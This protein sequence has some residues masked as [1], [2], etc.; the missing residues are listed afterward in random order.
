MQQKNNFFSVLKFTY[1]QGIKAKWFHITTTVVILFILVGLN[2]NSIGNLFN[3]SSDD[4]HKIAVMNNTG[5]VSSKDLLKNIKSS[6]GQSEY[7][8]VFETENTAKNIKTKTSE[9]DALI[10]INKIGEKSTVYYESKVSDEVL[11]NDVI[12]MADSISRTLYATSCGLNSNQ[13]NTLLS[14][15]MVEKIN[16]SN[17]NYNLWILSFVFIILLYLMISVYGISIAN[18]IV[19]EKSNRIVETLLCYAKPF[20]LMF[21]KIFGF[22]CIA[23]TQISIWGLTTTAFIRILPIPDFAIQ[24]LNL[25]VLVLLVINILLG[26]LIYS[27]VFA[28]LA[29]FADNSQDSNQLMMPVTIILIVSLYSSMFI[30]IDPTQPLAYFFSYVPFLAPIAFTSIALAQENI[31][32]LQ[33]V[34]NC[35]VQIA[36]IIIVGIICSR[37][38]CKGVLGGKLFKGIKKLKFKQQSL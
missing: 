15:D 19:E 11:S 9:Y 24:H 13:I 2:I 21:G 30:S 17:T 33:I 10:V 23:L 14:K 5:T 1:L 3:S 31:S 18:S 28:A 34:I 20:D 25:K 38:Y 7:Y 4:I 35:C 27:C 6:S 36:E 8:E 32:T 12:G 29:S 16:Y 26:F 22:L 37:L